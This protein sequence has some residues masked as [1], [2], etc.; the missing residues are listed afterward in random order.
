MSNTFLAS[1]DSG[2]VVADD[3]A[4]AD[5]GVLTNNLSKEMWTLARTA[6][7]SRRSKNFGIS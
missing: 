6:S 5:V 3:V 2:V 1:S 7:R 4:V